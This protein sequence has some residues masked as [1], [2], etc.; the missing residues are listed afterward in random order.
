MVAAVAEAEAG[1]KKHATAIGLIR[2][3]IV[4]AGGPI[5]VVVP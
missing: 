4:R 2:P 5:A 1:T 3:G